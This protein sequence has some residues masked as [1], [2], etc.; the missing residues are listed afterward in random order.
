MSKKE[1]INK[2]IEEGK[3]FEEIVVQSGAK[4]SY[5]K[6]CFTKLG[7]DWEDADDPTVE[8]KV[9]IVEVAEEDIPEGAE[10]L[11]EG[12]EIVEVEV[13]EEKPSEPKES[14]EDF[15]ERLKET[16]LVDARKRRRL[17]TQIRKWILTD[18]TSKSLGKN[19]TLILRAEKLNIRGPHAKYI[20]RDLVKDIEAYYEFVK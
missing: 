18:V 10:V 3:S 13:I 17:Q 4:Q 2:L 6:S 12:L 8:L 20:L 7:K 9:E 14:L 1:I 11:E 19:K 5:V 15:I 16:V